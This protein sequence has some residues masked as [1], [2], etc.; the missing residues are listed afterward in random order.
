MIERFEA[1]DFLED[2][3]R[4]DISLKNENFHPTTIPSI[5]H[6]QPQRCRHSSHL[7]GIMKFQR[8][9]K[10]QKR[11]KIWTD[12]NLVL[13]QLTVRTPNVWSGLSRRQARY[14]PCTYCG[15]RGVRLTRDHVV[16]KSKGGPDHDHNILMVCSKCNQDKG[17][18]ALSTWLD[19]LSQHAP[20]RKTF[21]LI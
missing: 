2:R 11:R 1:L 16:P 3:L 7:L 6:D 9:T 21:G 12:G 20:Q 14:G 19:S 18:K 15:T 5:T 4:R 8:R 13:V 10:P 17:D